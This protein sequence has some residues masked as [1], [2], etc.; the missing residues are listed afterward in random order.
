MLR[1]LW[2]NIFY[3][4]QPLIKHICFLCFLFGLVVIGLLPEQILQLGELRTYENASHAWF[5]AHFIHLNFQHTVMNV[6]GALVIWLLCA[7]L[8]PAALLLVLMI[9]LPVS[10]S[11][12]LIF[13]SDSP[14]H[15]RGFSGMLEG[16][17]IVGVIWQWWLSRTFSVILACFIVGKIIT[18]QLPN[19]DDTYLMNSIGGLVA[20]DAHLYGF[21]CGIACAFIYLVLAIVKVPFCIAPW[22]TPWS[23]H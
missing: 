8:V 7:S 6:A 14:L 4:P 23:S 22:Q 12:G 2:A 10:I 17:F 18:E 5:S 9:I 13:L 3:P 19:F 15:Y 20:V 1:T 21:I 11:L 16:F